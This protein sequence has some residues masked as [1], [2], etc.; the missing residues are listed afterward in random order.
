MNSKI[1]SIAASVALILAGSTASAFAMRLVERTTVVGARD[2]VEAEDK[3]L[4]FAQKHKLMFRE[5]FKL[6]V[7][8]SW[9]C[10]FL[11]RIEL[12]PKRRPA[13]TIRR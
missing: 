6:T 3:C 8:E 10:S 12:P 5:V 7:K 11:Q 13:R 1:F 4:A 9:E 2:R